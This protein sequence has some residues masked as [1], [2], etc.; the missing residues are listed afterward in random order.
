MTFFNPNDNSAY[1]EAFW[2]GNANQGTSEMVSGSGAGYYSA[3]IAAT[4]LRLKYDSGTWLTGS[5]NLYG[6]KTS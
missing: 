3:A 1:N 4:G 6:M 5:W 2:Y